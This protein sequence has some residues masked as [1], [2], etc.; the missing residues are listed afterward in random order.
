[1]GDDFGFADDPDWSLKLGD[2][3]IRVYTDDE[4]ATVVYEQGETHQHLSPDR[5]R[6]M[7]TG[8]ERGPDDAERIVEE[9]REAAD[10]VEGI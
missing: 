4:T 3:P 1:M 9:L 2:G 6:E 8:L 10:R 5:A 7:A